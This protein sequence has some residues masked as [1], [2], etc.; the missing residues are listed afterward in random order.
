MPAGRFFHARAGKAKNAT[1]DIF[2]K[3]VFPIQPIFSMLRC[4]GWAVSDNSHRGAEGASKQCVRMLFLV[5]PFKWHRRSRC[6]RAI[7]RPTY[8]RAGEGLGFCSQPFFSPSA[9]SYSRGST[10]THDAPKEPARRTLRPLH[11]R[12]RIAPYA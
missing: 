7:L 1:F 10:S 2:S 5:R 8:G 3:V 6:I 11:R 4:Y 12:D 9:F